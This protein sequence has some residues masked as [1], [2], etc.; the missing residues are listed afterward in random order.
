MTNWPFDKA[1]FDACFIWH[2]QTI[3]NECS[4]LI[5][6]LG[7]RWANRCVVDREQYDREK[8]PCYKKDHGCEYIEDLISD[9]AV[10][11]WYYANEPYYKLKQCY[12]MDTGDGDFHDIKILALADIEK[13]C[14]VFSCDER[15]L[16]KCQAMSVEHYCLKAS[17][18]ELDDY[19][20]QGAIFASEAFETKHMIDGSSN[21][22]HLDFS[23]VIGCEKCDPSHRCPFDKLKSVYWE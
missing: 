15:V 2:L 19:L 8:N 17:L 20:G 7:E 23:D 14:V 10:A 22:K 13:G 1:I 6:Y 21:I 4:E 9:S 18:V 3:D 5:G 16:Q 12:S 11:E